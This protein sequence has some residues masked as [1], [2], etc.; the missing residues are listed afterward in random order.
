M[1]R[2]LVALRETMSCMLHF[3]ESVFVAQENLGPHAADSG[4]SGEFLQQIAKEVTAAPTFENLVHGLEGHVFVQMFLVAGIADA[5][6]LRATNNGE[7]VEF[8]EG[9]GGFRKGKTEPL[10]QYAFRQVHLENRKQSEGHAP[11]LEP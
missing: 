11:R 6:D 7:Q 10:P 1:G 2:A 8:V 3:G 5:P 9:A 4:E